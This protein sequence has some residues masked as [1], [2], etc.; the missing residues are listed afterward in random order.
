MSRTASVEAARLAPAS[1]SRRAG[2]LRRAGHPEADRRG[3][4]S[5]RTSSRSPRSPRRTLA[6]CASVGAR[7]A[8]R[9]CRSPRPPCR[10]VLVNGR[11]DESLSSLY[12]LPRGVRVR[13]LAR[14][15]AESPGALEPHLGRAATGRTPPFV[16]LNTALVR[17]RRSS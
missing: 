4:A 7:S 10:A 8:R 2:P 6:A 17:G 5:D 1:P 13:S 11:F 9:A 15:L 12:A 3:L 16:A 14:A